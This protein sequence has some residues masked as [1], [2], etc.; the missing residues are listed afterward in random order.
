MHLGRLLVS[1]LMVFALLAGCATKGDSTSTSGTGAGSAPTH[2]TASSSGTHA[3]A[4]S[5]A[6]GNATHKATLTANKANGTAPLNVTFTV[7]ALGTARNWTLAFGDKNQT[8]GSSVPANV[9]HRYLVGGNLTATLTVRFT[10][11]STANATVKLTFKASSGGGASP[12]A[13]LHKS[14]TVT[15]TVQGP[16]SPTPV[17]CGLQGEGKDL[18]TYPWV[19]NATVG[20]AAAVAKNIKINLAIGGSAPNDFD[21]YFLDPAGNEIKSSVD[22]NALTGPKEAI[23]LPGPYVPGTYKV[24]VQGCIVVAG[25]FTL[26]ATADIVAK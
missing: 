5:A 16:G 26:D 14:G 20:G 13:K 7:G 3:I 12:V 8:K 18:F 10:D 17:G 25:S 19:F 23:S 21:L 9:T 11:N 6:A 22:S 4:F 1:V 24:Q 2:A 15:A